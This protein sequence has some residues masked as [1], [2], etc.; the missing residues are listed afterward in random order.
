M[1]RILLILSI[2]AA[3]FATQAQSV[4]I[5]WKQI[6]TGSPGQ[7]A[8]VGTDGNGA[9][10]TPVFTSW[11]DTLTFIATKTNVAVANGKE[12]VSGTF[13]SGSTIF[14]KANG[15][16]V[17]VTG[18]DSR[19][20]QQSEKAAV[21]GVASLGADGKVPSTQLPAL[22]GRNTFVVASQAAMLALSAIKGDFAIRTDNSNTYV[23]QG[24]DPTVLAN[25]V[26]LPT[27]TAPVTSVNGQIGSVS[28]STDNVSEGSTNKYVTDP[29]VRGALSAT[30]P[31]TYNSTT[32]AIGL[33]TVGTAGTYN[34][35]TTDANGRVTAGSNV[36]YTVPADL[37]N[38]YTKTNVQ[39][40]GQAAIHWNNLTGVPS[41][42]ARTDTKEQFTA[43]TSSAIALTNTPIV[44]SAVI[45]F[46]N[47][48]ALANADYTL[49]GNSLTLG[50]TRESSDLITV[51]YMY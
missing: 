33:N 31:I 13:S 43:S 47:G 48:V 8:I 10:V 25:W 39:T 12:I 41:N 40:A 21:N 35:V 19:Y 44:P 20:L 30:A 16:T 5:K 6:A 2:V 46:L 37:N 34:N 50:F 7:I 22:P 11:T 1:K 49:T 23:L 42:L 15:S 32:G 45:V 26:A 51:K 14:T 9:W 28:L 36:T 27:T 38:Y 3:A 29:R 17:T 24:T 4:K 18:Y